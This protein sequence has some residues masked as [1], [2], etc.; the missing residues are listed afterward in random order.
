MF[1]TI[2]ALYRDLTGDYDT[3]IRP[4]TKIKDGL[5]LSSLGKVQLICEIEDHFEIEIPA[6]DLKSFKTVQSIVD[7]VEKKI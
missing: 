7:Y 2:V 6:E 4:K 1:E 5:H 3:E